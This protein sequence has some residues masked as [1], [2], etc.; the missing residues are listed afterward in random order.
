MFNMCLI[1]EMYVLNVLNIIIFNICLTNIKHMRSFHVLNTC[2]HYIKL[3]GH[4]PLCILLT[5]E[6]YLH[7]KKDLAMSFSNQI[8]TA[9]NAFLKRVYEPYVFMYLTQLLSFVES[10]KLLNPYISVILSYFI[11]LLNITYTSN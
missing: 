6:V 4:F 10:G 9:C 1:M 5:R 8:K 2:V 11:Y 7:K 3:C